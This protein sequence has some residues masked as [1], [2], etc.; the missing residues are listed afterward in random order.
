MTEEIKA[1]RD[2]LA[3]AAC[4]QIE[5]AIKRDMVSRGHSR[6]CANE[7]FKA[8][9]DQGFALAMEDVEGIR[10]Q[11]LAQCKMTH[12]L[13][14]EKNELKEAA[15]VLVEALEAIELDNH[16]HSDSYQI[17]NQALKEFKEKTCVE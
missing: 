11:L 12:E 14:D 13:L 10:K 6:V 2:D 8:G 15:K 1:K 5:P 4:R 17:A 16:V 7:G 3:L 9:F